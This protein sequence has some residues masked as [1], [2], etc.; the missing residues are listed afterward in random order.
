MMLSRK[1]FFREGARALGRTLLN[2]GR[3]VASAPQPQAELEPD[4]PLAIDNSRC[5]AQRLHIK[6]TGS[7]QHQHCRPAE[8]RSQPDEAFTEYVG[9][10]HRH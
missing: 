7:H 1:E 6:H 10:A 8:E 5:L 4:G 2:P 9:P 3:L